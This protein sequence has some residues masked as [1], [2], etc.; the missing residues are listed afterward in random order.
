MSIEG[1]DLEHQPDPA[2]RQQDD[3]NQPPVQDDADDGIVESVT[4]GGQKMVPLSELI[5]HRRASRDLKRQVAELAPKLQRAEQ[6]EAQ[7]R[8]AEPILAAIKQNP[9]LIDI[10]TKATHS[11]QAHVEQ[12]SDDLEARDLAQDAGW[13]VPSTGELDVARAQRWLTKQADKARAEVDRAIAP[14]RQQTAQ[15]G[16]A[17]M[18]A[19]VESMRDKEGAPLASQESLNDIWGMVPPELQAD[20]RVAF[21]LT[22]AASGMDKYTGRRPAAPAPRQE[23]GEPIYTEAPGRRGG[24]GI[25][26]ELAALGKRVGLSESDLASSVQRQTGRGGAVSFE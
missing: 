10:A 19:K 6:I 22:L 16:A 7:L 9:K 12:P 8:E 5:T 1:M 18:R 23:Y 20:P 2:A 24:G 3:I 25:S 11:T 15:Q 21:V 26:S 4:V 13:Y 14:L 17:A